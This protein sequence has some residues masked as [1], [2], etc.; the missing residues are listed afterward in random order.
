MQ[1]LSI[2]IIVII[3]QVDLTGKIPEVA[4]GKTSALYIMATV[5][6]Y[7]FTVYGLRFLNVLCKA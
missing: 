1:A 6:G 2:S 3:F 7:Q 5:Y 4:S